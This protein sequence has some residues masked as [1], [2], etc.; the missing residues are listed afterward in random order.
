MDNSTIPVQC[1]KVLKPAK[2][3][4]LSNKDGLKGIYHADVDVPALDSWFDPFIDGV[5][6][7]ARQVNH[8]IMDALRW[9]Y[10]QLL[11]ITHM[12]KFRVD[13]HPTIRLGKKDAVAIWAQ[14]CMH[15]CLPSLPNI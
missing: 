15:W 10:I 8:L 14:D 7:E 6:K 9:A 13:A 2:D 11:D 3:V 12:S 1:T 4:N 5:N